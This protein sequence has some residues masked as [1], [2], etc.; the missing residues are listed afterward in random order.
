MNRYIVRLLVVVVAT[1][2]GLATAPIL[3]A[4]INEFYPADG[5]WI[6][7]IG[8]AI[9]YLVVAFGFEAAVKKRA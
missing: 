1:L 6:G 9:W 3:V 5:S 4:A 2:A 8:V 7:W